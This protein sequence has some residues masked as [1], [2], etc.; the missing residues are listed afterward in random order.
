MGAAIVRA[1]GRPH[2]QTKPQELTE[3]ATFTALKA[4]MPHSYVFPNCPHCN[5]QVVPDTKRCPA[6]GNAFGAEVLARWKAQEAPH[7]GSARWA[8]VSM[9]LDPLGRTVGTVVACGLLAFVAYAWLVYAMS[10]GP[11]NHLNA[12]V[13]TGM[14]L[15][16]AYE[17]WAFTHGRTTHIDQLRQ[18]ATLANTGWRTVGL[19]L[20]VALMLV[21]VSLFWHGV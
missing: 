4:F 7:F 20:D 13:M 5:E 8:L 12:F 1:G 10:S 16:C 14:A 11:A 2:N 15:F 3:G 18:R 6:C 9:G 17:I 19:V 21:C